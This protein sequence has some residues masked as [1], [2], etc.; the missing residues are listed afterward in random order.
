MND[1]SNDSQFLINF[2]PDFKAWDIKSKCWVET[3]FEAQA[4][5]YDNGSYRLHPFTGLLDKEGKK[6][7]H[8]DILSIDKEYGRLMEA[9]RNYFL[10]GFCHGS[11]MYGRYLDPYHMNTYLWLY[12]KNLNVVGNIYEHR[13]L[14]DFMEN[15]E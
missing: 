11:F 9:Y 7:Y 2:N 15:V 3:Y 8:A 14:L 13:D 12:H 10:V 6:I 1:F 5:H 4:A